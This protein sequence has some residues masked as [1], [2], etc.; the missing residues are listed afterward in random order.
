M[1]RVM[2][3]LYAS[4]GDFREDVVDEVVN[5]SR[6]RRATASNATIGVT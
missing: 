2:H 5:A 3:T 4:E 6:H 1:V